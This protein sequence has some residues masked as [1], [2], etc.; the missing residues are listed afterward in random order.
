[1]SLS[2]NDGGRYFKCEDSFLRP[3]GSLTLC[4]GLGE[5]AVQ[6]ESRGNFYQRLE[7]TL[8]RRAMTVEHCRVHVLSEASTDGTGRSQA[9]ISREGKAGRFLCGG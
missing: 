8:G 7:G 6:V 9:E 2:L 1:M 5:T 3:P 4:V